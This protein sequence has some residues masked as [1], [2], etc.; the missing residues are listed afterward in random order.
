LPTL[1]P[2]RGPTPADPFGGRSFDI[3]DVMDQVEREAERPAAVEPPGETLPF[4]L[5][6]VETAMVEAVIAAPEPEPEP[7]PVAAEPAPVMPEPVMPESAMAEAAND[8]TA[9]PAIRPIVI[10]SAEAPAAEKKRGWWR[11]KG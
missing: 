10:G 6:P 9:A 11:S 5:L 3:F 2:Y 1:E 7:E 4:E 8:A